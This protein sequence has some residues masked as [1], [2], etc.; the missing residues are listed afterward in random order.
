MAS[1]TGRDFTRLVMASARQATPTL[2]VS[3]GTHRQASY[4]IAL[5]K[6]MDNARAEYEIARALRIGKKTTRAKN[7]LEHIRAQL[8]KRSAKLLRMSDLNPHAPVWIPQALR[9]PRMMRY[10]AVSTPGE[11]HG[12]LCA[13]Q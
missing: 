12:V 7:V 6:A 3:Y 8:M 5:R 13:Q 11:T 2:F 1:K 4:V 10:H 9:R